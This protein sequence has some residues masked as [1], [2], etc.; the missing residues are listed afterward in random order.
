MNER[1]CPV[2]MGTGHW[3]RLTGQPTY[4]KPPRPQDHRCPFCEGTGKVRERG[5][6]P[7]EGGIPEGE[8]GHD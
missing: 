1:P 6:G 8:V 3:D 7:R 5:E 2:C 4:S